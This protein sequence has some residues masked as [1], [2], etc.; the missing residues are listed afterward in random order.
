MLNT[1]FEDEIWTNFKYLQFQ[2]IIAFTV[3]TDLTENCR[4]NSLI[5]I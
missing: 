4:Q 5:M 1:I 3:E 2:Y